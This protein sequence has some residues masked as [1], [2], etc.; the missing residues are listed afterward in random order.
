MLKNHLKITLRN[1]RKHSLYSLINI[2][3]LTVALT[4]AIFLLLYITDELSYDRHHQYAN[5]IYRVAMDAKFGDSERKVAVGPA[6]L[7]PTLQTSYPEV[8]AYALVRPIPNFHLKKADQVMVQPNVF[9]ASATTFDV[10]SYQIL[11]GNP[12]TM[13][14]EPNS[15]VISQ[16]LAKKYFGDTSENLMG[17]SVIRED[18][19]EYRVTGLMADVT[20]NGH[21]TPTAFV[22]IW[23]KEK[24][25]SWDDWNWHNYILTQPG[26]SPKGFQK[27]LEAVAAENLSPRLAV[28]G[29]A[30]ITFVLQPLTDIHF[31]SKRDFEIQANDGNMA[32]IY[33]F[34]FVAF[35]LILLAAINYI[36]LSTARALQ[37]A[38]EVGV[39]K[40]LGAGRSQLV[41]QFLGESLL[42]TLSA[43][44]LSVLLIYL[45]TP[46]FGYFS[47]KTINFDAFVNLESLLWLSALLVIL[48]L[49]SGA[50]PAF[51]L[52]RFRPSV[53]LKGGKGLRENVLFRK[54]LVVSQFSISL[55]LIMCTMMVYMQL[56]YLQQSDLGFDQH[57]VVKIS[58]GR[59]SK[60]HLLPL[61][62]ALLQ[63]PD[64]KRIGTAGYAPGDKPP[65]NTFML[66]TDEGMQNHIFQQTW[67]DQD[68]L[69]TLDIELMTGRN[70]HDRLPGDTTQAGVLVNE[71]LVKKMGWT[72]DNAIGKKLQSDEWADEV[73]GV[74]KDFHMT[75]LH[76]VIEPLIIRHQI[77]ENYMLVKISKNNLSPTL[78]FVRHK[79][80]EIVGETTLEYTFLDQHFQQQYEADEKRGRLFA[81]FSGIIIFIACLGLFGLATFTAGQRTKEIGIRKVMGA[82]VNHILFLLSKDYLQLLGISIVIAIPVANYF[83]TDWL[84]GFA[85]KIPLAWW[86]FVL[87]GV[88]VLLIA[89]ISISNKTIKVARKNPVE[90]LRYE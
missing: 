80:N 88:I 59:E 34:S 68:F 87:P 26:F 6:A 32:Y 22:S 24:T 10:F 19:T 31:Y 79:W 30:E 35:F 63:N 76:D 82:S 41:F 83:I 73:I 14:T 43:I 29:N 18:G 86:M 66:E 11:Q 25:Q 64:I 74:V 1:V 49:L 77:P 71:T 28:R 12:Q 3:G 50:Y 56:N 15:I 36:N 78:D 42:F 58:M 54:I 84:K 16:N 52:S 4:G 51:F 5:R 44:L 57:Q 89:F 39:R 61:K 38:K 17:K 33:T 9:Y 60:H 72:T 48:T 62:D 46:A 65:I 69:P 2:L 20:K 67:V 45:F 23:D 37:R 55:V 40:T 7:S 75:S 53:V 90:S 21:F 85:Y 27:N 70:F 13:L 8:E 81:I 47:G